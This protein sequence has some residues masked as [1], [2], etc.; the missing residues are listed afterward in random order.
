MITIGK[1]ESFDDTKENWE[2]YVE[3][4]EQCW[5]TTSMMTIKCQLC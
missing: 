4:V 3:R 5:R 1:I 2:T